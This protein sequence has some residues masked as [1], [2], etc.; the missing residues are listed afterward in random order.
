MVSIYKTWSPFTKHGLSLQN[1]VSDYKT[2]S[3]FTKHGLSL[4]RFNCTVKPVLRG[5]D[6]WDN[7]IVAL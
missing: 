7:E 3:Q 4:D 5:H 2:W 6:L 1:M